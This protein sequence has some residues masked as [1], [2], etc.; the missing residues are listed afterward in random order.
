MKKLIIGILFLLLFSQI[1]FADDVAVAV[2]NRVG[3]LDSEHEQ[4]IKDLLEGMGHVVTLIDRNNVNSINFD[5]FDLI[6]ITGKSGSEGDLNYVENIPVNSHKTISIYKSHVDEWKWVESSG[7][8]AFTYSGQNINLNDQGYMIVD[9]LNGDELLIN[10]AGKKINYVETEKTFLNSVANFADFNTRGL[11]LIADAG[12]ELLNGTEISERVGFFGI[13]SP[14]FWTQ[15]TIDTFENFVNWVL[16]GLDGDGD[17]LRD[18]E[19]NCPMDFNPDQEDDDGDGIGNVCDNE[20]PVVELLSP[21]DGTEFLVTGNSKLVLFNFMV[22]D[23]SSPSLNCQM[24]ADMNNSVANP[25]KEFRP[26]GPTITVNNGDTGTVFPG[27]FTII[28]GDDTVQWNVLCDDGD[29]N[30]F[31][32]DNFIMSVNFVSCAVDSDCGDGVFCNGEEVCNENFECAAGNPPAVDDSVS[33]TVD[34][35]DEDLDVIVNAPDDGFCSNGLFCDGAEVCDAV[36][37]CQSGT[38]PTCDDDN[39]D[40]ADSCSVELDICVNTACEST[41]TCDGIDN[42]CDGI[43]DEGFGDNDSDGI[44]DCV[45]FDDDNDGLIDDLESDDTDGFTTDPLNPDTD[46]DGLLDGEEDSNANGQVDDNETDPLNPDTDGDGVKDGADAFPLDA[47]ESEDTD[48]DGIGDN[49]DD[50][51][52]GDGILNGDDFILGSTA[53]IETNNGALMLV[54]ND[55][56][57]PNNIVGEGSVSIVGENN[58]LIE[59]P[60]VFGN[61]NI[62]DT[63]RIVVNT[64]TNGQGSIIINGITLQENDT[65]TAYIDN[66]N[67]DTNDVC[68]IDAE[69]SSIAV[70]GDC[71]NGVKVTCNG[72]LTGQ[73]TCE[74]VNNETLYKISGLTH[75]AVTEHV[76]PPA[77][78]GTSGGGGGGGGGGSSGNNQEMYRTRYD[79]GEETVG[80]E[81]NEEEPEV[82]PELETPEVTNKPSPITGNVVGNFLKNNRPGVGIAIIAVILAVTG[83]YGIK[84]KGF[85]KVKKLL[86]R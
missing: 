82:V 74:S 30:A 40:T 35:C 28:T 21:E 44:A 13:P 16:Y 71:S 31:A 49:S 86:K 15:E 1:V 36:L 7:S 5:D 32:D 45:D 81:P 77:G 47:E 6:V 67:I 29:E 26:F 76:T 83:V 59:F 62:L 43:I 4:P 85:R 84:N 54:V 75:S 8:G 39:N 73:Y 51:I 80:E 33:C 34:S 23:D 72:I 55:E 19:D 65:K 12:S 78:G 9:G 52:D 50:D 58:T 24:Y 57:N 37:D 38:V 22:T 2:K 60:Y 27:F 46:G 48:G 53:N 18:G 25:M 66:I 69:V 3:I 68:I 64:N 42:T 61:E 56:E 20:S 11:L 79:G 63:R 41:E 17:G 70:E 14:G 10:A